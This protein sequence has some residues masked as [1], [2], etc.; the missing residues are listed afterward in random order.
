MPLN[1]YVY[2]AGAGNTAHRQPRPNYGT[3]AQS[4]GPRGGTYG[5]EQDFGMRDMFANAQLQNM[6]QGYGSMMNGLS[7]IYGNAAGMVTSGQ[8]ATARGD[9][10]Q[11]LADFG[12]QRDNGNLTDAQEQA[13]LQDAYQQTAASTRAMQGGVNSM[14]ASR[15]L[16]ANAGLTAAMSMAGQFAA[17][18]NRGR[19]NA[20]IMQNEGLAKERGR[21]GYAG[22]SGQRAQYA[23]MPT[24]ENALAMAS[25]LQSAYGS[26]Q[27]PNFGGAYDSWRNAAIGP[28]GGLQAGP[29]PQTPGFN[30]VPTYN[31]GGGGV[32]GSGGG[33]F[34]GGGYI[35]NPLRQ[36]RR[37]Y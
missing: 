35:T 3:P 30:G 15:G 34:G 21:Q 17:A 4:T 24:Q 19:A 23:A 18:G 33:N 13:L 9:L 14:N 29:P 11:S 27:Q 5:I 8:I 22:V 28:G 20:D 6:N 25:Q 37:T 7:G 1:S 2:G 36:T 10:A 32:T 31:Y 26:M 16:G 12:Y